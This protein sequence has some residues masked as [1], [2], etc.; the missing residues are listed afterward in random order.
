MNLND[1][2][3]I[4]KYT[5]YAV[6]T[7]IFYI[8]VKYALPLAI[9]FIIGLSI[10]GLVQKPAALLASRIPR[11]GKKNCCKIMTSAVVFTAAVILYLGLC[12]AVKG[13]MSVCPG[14]PELFGRLR[15]A[16]SAA[17]EG[18]GGT[19]SWERFASFIASGANWCLDLLTENYRQ[20]MPSVLAR[21]TKLISGIPS[22]ITALLFTLLSA[23]F[24]CGDFD[25]IRLEVKRLLPGEAAEKV[26][27]IIRTS[28]DTVAALI[29]TYGTIMLLTFAELTAG[30]GI[31]SLMGCKTGN[32]VT[33]SLL[34]SLIDILPVLGTG[35]V[36]IPWGLFVILSGNTLSGVLLIALF[37]VIETV[38]NFLEPKLISERLKLNPVFT[39]AGVYIGGKLFGVT[40]I[41]AL[42]LAIMI[43]RRIKEQKTGEAD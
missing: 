9:P 1:S 19:G 25:G 27:L 23:F 13:A 16:I 15:Q 3:S 42:P 32:I 20:Y 37:V 43:F 24:G 29:K 35:T 36:L 26:S 31:M 17:S 11:L 30:L 33:I 5:I 2:K 22:L 41:F 34:I 18:K 40:G 21:S 7:V 8:A 14:I 10:A 28:A 39:L 38:R 12:T 4:V 6:C